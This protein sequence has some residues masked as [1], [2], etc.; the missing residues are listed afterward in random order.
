[1]NDSNIVMYHNNYIVYD[2]N[3]KYRWREQG[4]LTDN[5]EG[6]YNQSPLGYLLVD[7]L[8]WNL[9]TKRRQST[10]YT[11]A[12]RQLARFVRGINRTL[13]MP[14]LP[15]PPKVH[16]SNCTI[17][18]WMDTCAYGFQRHIDFNYKA[19]VGCEWTGSCFTDSKSYTTPDP[20]HSF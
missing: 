10:P 14:V 18:A 6:Y 13:I 1:M 5:D 15:C 16:A 9:A 8:H 4:L 2:R 17:C 20:L 11:E 3:K 12:I 7:N 19:H